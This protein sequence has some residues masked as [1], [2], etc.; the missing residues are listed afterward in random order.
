MQQHFFIKD[1]STV[2]KI[3]F[4]DISLIEGTL[5]YCKIHTRQH[6]FTTL[7]TMKKIMEALPGDEFIRVHKS[8]IVAV[9]HIS[10]IS[11]GQVHLNTER[12]VPIGDT[13]RQGLDSMVTKSLL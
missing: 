4:S 8:Y 12:F 9:Q 2:Y 7:V 3:N 5:N 10:K 11:R 13:F 1:R 6:S